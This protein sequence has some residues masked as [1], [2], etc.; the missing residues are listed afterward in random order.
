METTAVIN[1]GLTNETTQ[2]AVSGVASTLVVRKLT[3]KSRL[4]ELI[5][6]SLKSRTTGV[7]RE[8]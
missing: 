2:G 5:F 3:P 6:P 8:G 4:S 1:N 7:V